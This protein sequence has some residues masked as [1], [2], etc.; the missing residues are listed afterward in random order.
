MRH[1]HLPEPDLDPGGLTP[2][3]S[4]T[5]RRGGD[6]GLQQ[7]TQP[8]LAHQDRQGGLG[9]TL[10]GGHLAPKF[11]RVLAAGVQEGRGADVPRDKI[12]MMRT[13]FNRLVFRAILNTT[14]RSLNLIKKRVGTRNRVAFT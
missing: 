4:R 9:R 10:W 7:G 1:G 11:G 14:T 5:A 13:L 6:G 8:A 2:K 12:T 3:L